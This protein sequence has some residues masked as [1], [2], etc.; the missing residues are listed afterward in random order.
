MERTCSARVTLLKRRETLI[1]L[2]HAD[3]AFSDSRYPRR[4]FSLAKRALILGA[5]ATTIAPMTQVARVFGVALAVLAAAALVPGCSGSSGSSGPDLGSPRPSV[6]AGAAEPAHGR[7]S[8]LELTAHSC[9][10]TQ[11]LM[12]PAP[13]WIGRATDAN[14]P[15]S[16]PFAVSDQGNAAAFLFGYPLTTPSRPDMSNK[17]LW[18]VRTPSGGQPLIITARHLGGRRPVVRVQLS[19]DSMPAEIYPSS[20]D[21]PVP[22]CWHFHAAVAARQ[23]NR[24]PAVH[25]QRLNRATGQGR[26]G[27]GRGG[28]PI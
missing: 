12:G 10:S 3:L 26:C 1:Y 28:S 6:P 21:L 24:Q 25:G 4:P 11:L 17:I 16:Y 14:T 18:V 5:R 15:T 22:G 7:P 9:G 13:A 20:I 8:Q 23:R 27:Q 2:A 19:A